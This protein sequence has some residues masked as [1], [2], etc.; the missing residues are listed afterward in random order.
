[1][2]R[3]VTVSVLSALLAA[4]V[5]CEAGETRRASGPARAVTVAVE[6]AP[7]D[8]LSPELTAILRQ[9]PGG[10]VLDDGIDLDS[11][12]PLALRIVLEP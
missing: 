8:E 11:D 1:M 3:I 4:W 9:G 12:S 6:Q 10:P 2:A 5:G 7:S